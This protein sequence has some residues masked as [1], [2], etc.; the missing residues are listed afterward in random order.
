MPCLQMANT[1]AVGGRPTLF[2][3]LTVSECGLHGCAGGNLM[4]LL[5]PDILHLAL[6]AA[7]HCRLSA[8]SLD[9][10]GPRYAPE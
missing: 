9:T 8:L 6:G 4:K 3:E 7:A 2:H 1:D 10:S 5:R